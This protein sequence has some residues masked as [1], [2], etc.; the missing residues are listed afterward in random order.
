MTDRPIIRISTPV[1][2]WRILTSSRTGDASERNLDDTC[3]SREFSERQPSSEAE[4]GRN[5][6][7]A[8]TSSQGATTQAWP[9]STPYG[10]TGRCPHVRE[11]PRF[12][13]NL[14]RPHRVK[15]PRNA[16]PLHLCTLETIV[17]IL[18]FS[19]VHI[20]IRADDSRV[21]WTE[22][23]R[24]WCKRRDPIGYAGG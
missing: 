23:Y 4:G 7:P 9:V 10:L 8:S 11:H 13:T 5:R 6:R 24:L 1:R 2:S 21:P 3:R 14:N 18:F 17:K 15:Q 19:D 16:I 22:I 20:E 12:E